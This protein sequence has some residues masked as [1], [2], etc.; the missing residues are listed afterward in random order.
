MLTHATIS[1]SVSVSG[2]ASLSVT[3][4]TMS[5]AVSAQGSA[6]LSLHSAAVHFTTLTSGSGSIIV[7][8]SCSASFDQQFVQVN[9]V[10]DACSTEFDLSGTALS[11]VQA[12][13]NL[14]H[15]LNNAAEWKLYSSPM[16]V[17]AR[18]AHAQRR[19]QSP[20]RSKTCSFLRRIQ[21]SAPDRSAWWMSAH[22]TRARTAA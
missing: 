18:E 15:T 13:Y 12:G 11:A 1:G 19:P 17:R 9:G 14:P 10:L 22:R 21:L 8:D 2:L 16:Y 5:G 6:V 3:N 20:Q 7:M 4:A